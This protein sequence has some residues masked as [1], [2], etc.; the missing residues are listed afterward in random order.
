MAKLTKEEITNTINKIKKSKIILLDVYHDRCVSCKNIEPVIEKL[1][2]DYS[3]NPD[4]VFL[5]YDL[6]NPFTV[7]QSKKIAKAAGLEDIYKSQRYSGIVLIID[8]KN[9]KIIDS[10]ISEYDIQKY[11]GV[12]QRDLAIINAT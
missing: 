9:K 7:L 6:S 3:G 2:A 4:I 1:K 11:Y 8:S 10:L 5:K 12:I